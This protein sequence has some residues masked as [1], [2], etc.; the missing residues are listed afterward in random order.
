MLIS[1]KIRL[2]LGMDIATDVGTAYDAFD[3]QTLDD[4]ED[5]YFTPSN[6][7]EN[8]VVKTEPTTNE[9]EPEFIEIPRISPELVVVDERLVETNQSFEEKIMNYLQN[10]E[11]AKQRRHEE[12]MELKKKQLLLLEKFCSSQNKK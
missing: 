10:K 5:D 9:I 11:I 2:S 12:N 6:T 3:D 8:T 1:E 4:D 7:K